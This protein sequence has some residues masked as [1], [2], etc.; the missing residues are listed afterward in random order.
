MS[1]SEVNRKIMSI[2]ATELSPASAWPANAFVAESPE[3]HFP[4]ANYINRDLSLLEFHQRVLEEALDE[5]LPILERLKFI[6]IF[7][8]N[9]DE[10][11]MIRVSVLKEKLGHEVG[12]SPDGF[13]TVEL[14]EEIRVRLIKMSGV[15]TQCL[16]DDILPE[17]ERQGIVI[18]PYGSL[19]DSDRIHVDE[20]FNTHIYPLLTPQAVDPSHPFPRI[21]SGSMN[22]G[23][24]V[25]LKLIRHLAR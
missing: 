10:F 25:K 21:S 17:L 8:S 18:S 16:R 15:M 13:T 24:L 9:L 20:Y 23:L 5:S 4:A 14:L 2:N 1:T 6:S 12:V 19:S 11:F 22:I 7:A 3:L